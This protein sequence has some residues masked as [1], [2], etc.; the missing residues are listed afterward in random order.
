MLGSHMNV[1]LQPGPPNNLNPCLHTAGR[2]I[3]GAIEGDGLDGV[4]VLVTRCVLGA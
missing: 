4:A 3:L 2:P 1:L